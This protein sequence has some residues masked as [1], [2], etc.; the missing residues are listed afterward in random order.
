MDSWPPR[1]NVIIKALLPALGAGLIAVAT[2]AWSLE[3]R[4][5]VIEARQ[6]RQDRD[7]QARD[8]KIDSAIDGRFADYR[9]I[10]QALG[11]IRVTVKGIESTLE[12]AERHR[13]R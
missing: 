3:S 11:E 6:N 2:W 4:M 9:S 10:Q 1:D 5:A 7:G 13:R 8:Q 12:K